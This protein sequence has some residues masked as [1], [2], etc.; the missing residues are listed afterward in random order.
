RARGIES[1]FTLGDQSLA[2]RGRHF[3]DVD[4]L[5]AA[6]QAEL[7]KVASV[8]VKGSRFMKMER[9]VEAIMA[10]GVQHAA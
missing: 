7:P 1:F 8:L 3:A 6:V 5:N 9:V 4:A 2:M 10:K